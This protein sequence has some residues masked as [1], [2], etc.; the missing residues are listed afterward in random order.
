M[1]T[2]TKDDVDSTSDAE[3]DKV[4]EKDAADTSAETDPTEADDVDAAEES[5]SDAPK[6]D[7]D[8]DSSGTSSW[9]RYA[10]IGAFAAILV[11]ALVFSGVVG[12]KVW[13][14]HQIDAAG[15]QAQAV[16]VAYTEVLTSV[17]SDK[18]DENFRQILNGATGKFKDDF[19]QASIQLR[20]LLI[21][22]KSGA[23]GKVVNSAIESKST[24]K[25]V[26]LMMV[27]QSVKNVNVRD[28]RVDKN[29]M[30]ITMVKIDGRWL[31]SDLT[32]L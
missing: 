16:A 9:V 6:A 3:A 29:R 25:V 10:A 5:D 20:Q 7:D 13:R 17:E 21:D 32:Y 22:N 12:M 2:M 15:E 30:K 27:D 28:Q 14:Q 26:I 11:G 19:T 8:A 31:A 1:V 4:D 24:D 18:I 23:E